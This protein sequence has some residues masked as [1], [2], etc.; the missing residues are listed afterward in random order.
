M[1]CKFPEKGQKKREK[2]R[3]SCL[4]CHWRLYVHH[5][6]NVIAKKIHQRR[7]YYLK[8]QKGSNQVFNP[9]MALYFSQM[10]AEKGLQMSA[11][12][13]RQLF[14]TCSLEISGFLDELQI[15]MSQH[16]NR[17]HVLLDKHAEYFQSQ[18]RALSRATC[19]AQLYKT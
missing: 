18:Y 10:K 1:R 5:V 15:K 6:V 4:Q 13:R 16:V 3:C 7:S 19:T 14:H 8:F 11:V 12:L 9:K 17:F 2:Q